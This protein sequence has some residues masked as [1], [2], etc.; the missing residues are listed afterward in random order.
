M[1]ISCTRDGQDPFFYIGATHV[2]QSWVSDEQCHVH[3]CCFISNFH[4]QKTC[5]VF[6]NPCHV[7]MAQLPTV[8]VNPN[9]YIYIFICIIFVLDNF[10]I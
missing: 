7:G 10:Y 1:D 4:L 8:A 2:E 6:D 9:S 3:V 5:H